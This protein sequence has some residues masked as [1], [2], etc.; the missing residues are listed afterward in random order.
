MFISG[1]T[2][3]NIAE[4]DV[5]LLNMPARLLGARRGLSILAAGIHQRP[6]GE[7]RPKSW[8]FRRRHHADVRLS[9]ARLGHARP[10]RGAAFRDLGA[11]IAAGTKLGL[12][13][14]DGD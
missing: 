2:T 9:T 11:S 5:L 8:P 10:P 7:A 13:A 14:G 12:E 4:Y 6:A 3:R 1:T